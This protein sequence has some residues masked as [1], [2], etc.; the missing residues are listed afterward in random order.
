M[1]LKER[2]KIA[3]G[4]NTEAT[5]TEE[6]KLAY[7]AK[8]E[9]GTIIVSEADELAAGIVLNILSEDGIQTPMPEGNYK[10]EDG[11][12]FSVD[13]EGLV[14][15]VVEVEVEE[16]DEDDLKEEEDDKRMYSEETMLQEV[17]AVVNELLE[18]VR[19]D[20]SRLTA[21]LE[22]LR[23]ENLAKDENIVDL[24]KENVELS[25]Q[26]EDLK[27]EPSAE[28]TKVSKFADNKKRV[29]LSATDYAKLTPQ[30]K[31]LYNF[32]NK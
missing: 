29:E 8:L 4:L 12:G 20:I 26:V 25:K 23:G 5:N 27:D 31:Y 2:I 7:E 30:Q 10:L 19:N 18:E 24:Q 22:E 3:L 6:I 32:N 28:P 9:D 1:E 16:E 15:E 17:G 11:T 21:E 14:T 13:A